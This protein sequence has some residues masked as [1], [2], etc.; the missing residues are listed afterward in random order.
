MG[1]SNG[2]WVS[3]VGP[4]VGFSQV[5]QSGGSAESVEFQI[6]VQITFTI[7]CPYVT[8]IHVIIQMPIYFAANE[9]NLKCEFTF[10]PNTESTFTYLQNLH[11]I[12]K[13]K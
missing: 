10:F 7:F 4:V 8:K 11:W 1:Q 3:E 2:S 9:K 5:G 12:Y 13:N 6:I